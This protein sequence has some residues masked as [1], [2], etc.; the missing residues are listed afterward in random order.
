MARNRMTKADAEASFREHYL[1][2]IIRREREGNSRVDEPMRSEAWN[3]YTDSLCK[4]G[5]ITERQYSNWTHPRWL[6]T[7]R[8]L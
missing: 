5:D 6:Y 2:A 3:N 8:S 1:P 7:C 4:D